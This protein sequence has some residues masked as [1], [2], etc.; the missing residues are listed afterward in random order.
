[1]EKSVKTKTSYSSNKYSR[2]KIIIHTERLRTQ[3]VLR[4]IKT[5]T[6]STTHT[7]TKGNIFI[8]N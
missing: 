7:K 2:K 8:I 5:S 3:P 6:K 1:M 4:A